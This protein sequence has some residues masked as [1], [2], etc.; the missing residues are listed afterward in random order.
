MASL[1]ANHAHLFNTLHWQVYML[2]LDAHYNT[3]EIEAWVQLFLTQF[4]EQDF[5]STGWVVTIS[6]CLSKQSDFYLKAATNC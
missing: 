1:Y 2:K 5:V 6:R 4:G 3:Y